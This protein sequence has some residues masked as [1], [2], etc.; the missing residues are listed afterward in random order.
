M[1]EEIIFLI[2]YTILEFYR[3]L[4]FKYLSKAG[5]KSVFILFFLLLTV[6]G[7]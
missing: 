3:S 7:F 6:I 5:V 1:Y 4:K 2:L